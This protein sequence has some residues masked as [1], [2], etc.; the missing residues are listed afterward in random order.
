MLL[1]RLAS[2]LSLL[3]RLPMCLLP[4][5]LLLLLALGREITPAQ[6]AIIAASFPENPTP[7]AIQERLTKLR[8]EQNAETTRLGLD[9][10]DQKPI[11]PVNPE[12]DDAEEEDN[13]DDDAAPPSKSKGKRPANDDARASSS[14]PTKK[15][16]RA[17][18]PTTEEGEQKPETAADLRE[19]AMLSEETLA[20]FPINRP[21]DLSIDALMDL[22]RARDIR[23]QAMVDEFLASATTTTRVRNTLAAGTNALQH[24]QN[25]LGQLVGEASRRARRQAAAAEEAEEEYLDEEAGEED[26]KGEVEDDDSDDEYGEDSEGHADLYD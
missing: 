16:K 21:C 17:H 15:T 1:N 25:L 11:H 9:T 18:Q 14:R 23:L 26:V 7:K 22:Q 3:I 19:K 10:A 20:A 5:Q 12:D 6:Y 4:H 24:N 13:D 8:K 2:G